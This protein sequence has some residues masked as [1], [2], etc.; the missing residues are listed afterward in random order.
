ML[1]ICAFSILLFAFTYNPFSPGNFFISPNYTISSRL[2]IE[3]ADLRE[4]PVM[5]L[6]RDIID[7]VSSKPPSLFRF[8][9]LRWLVDAWLTWSLVTWEPIRLGLN[10]CNRALISYILYWSCSVYMNALSEV[11]EALVILLIC[12]LVSDFMPDLWYSSFSFMISS[13]F[14]SISPSNASNLAFCFSSSLSWSSLIL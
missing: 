12:D 2:S 10:F 5:L 1:N 6:P 3:T 7:L 11:R 14:S 13:M 9:W 8:P 4:N